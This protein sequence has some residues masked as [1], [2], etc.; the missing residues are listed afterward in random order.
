MSPVSKLCMEERSVLTNTALKTM[1]AIRT[2]I[3]TKI[4]ATKTVQQY[5][6]P[7]IPTHHVYDMSLS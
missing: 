4:I 6:L 1:Q 5:I 3:V 7:K 2:D